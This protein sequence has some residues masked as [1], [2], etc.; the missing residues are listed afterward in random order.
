MRV[1]RDRTRYD[2]EDFH[3]FMA[4]RAPCT[5]AAAVAAARTELI[6]SGDGLDDDTAV[7]ALGVPATT[8]PGGA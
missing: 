3:A 6:G 7:L 4:A 2:E 8:A 5:A 1:D